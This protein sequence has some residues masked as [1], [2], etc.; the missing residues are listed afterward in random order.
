MMLKITL[1]LIYAVFGVAFSFSLSIIVGAIVAFLGSILKV[2]KYKTAW[3]A[4][5]TSIVIAFIGLILV[6]GMLTL[7]DLVG[8]ETNY[9]MQKIFFVT[10]LIPGLLTWIYP[11]TLIKLA[12]TEAMEGGTYKSYGLIWGLL[13]R[14]SCGF[15]AIIFT[16]GHLYHYLSL[17]WLAISLVFFPITV[18][19]APIYLVFKG[20]WGPLLLFTGAWLL[21]GLILGITSDD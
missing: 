21:G 11:V 16:V 15:V 18:F 2:N 14:Y 5:L 8:S 7:V 3:F 10:A 6:V 12:L 19:I 4:L 20:I 9:R 17:G 1:I 13:A